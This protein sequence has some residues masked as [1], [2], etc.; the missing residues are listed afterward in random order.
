ME[1]EK[2]TKTDVLIAVGSG[3]LT[4]TMDA[5]FIKDIDLREAHK[6]GSE[7]VQSFVT[8]FAR[9]RG[10]KDHDFANIVRKLE[11]EYPMAGDK[12]TNDFGSGNNHHLRDFSHHPTP[13][14]LF[15]SLLMQFT[16][17]GYG[18]DVHGNLIS[19][20]IPN[21]EPQSVFE[22][23][24]NGTIK[25]AFHL[26][27]DMAGSSSSLD[28]GKE[29]TGIP[30]PMLS[31]LKM[32]S[33]CPGIKRLFG[34]AANENAPNMNR[35]NF[36]EAC[37]D[38]FLGKTF[39]LRDENGRIIKESQIPF[40]LRTELGIVNE[41]LKNKQYI[42]VVLNEVIISA[43]YFISRLYD[44][45][46]HK[47]TF[48]LSDVAQINFKRCLPWGNKSL[49]H[50]RMI[51]TATFS[52]IDLS[53]AGIKA[54]IKNKDNKAGFALDFIQATNFWGLGDFALAS[55]SE[56]A[57][58]LRKSFEQFHSIAQKKKDDIIKSI[59]NGD[60]WLETAEM[61]AST[62]GMIAKMGSPIGF[63]F[64]AISVYEELS[65]SIK[66]YN[67]AKEERIKI[68]KACSERIALIQEN[69][70]LIDRT[71]S[72]Y[73]VSNY[74]VFEVAFN[75]MDHAVAT[76]NSDEFIEGN[77]M[78]QEKLDYDT[79]FKNQSEFDSLMGENSAF[80]L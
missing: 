33:S 39:L 21:W 80:K 8:A 11:K 72:D 35:Y 55:G 53:T 14:G 13:L 36:S 16:G 30:G 71:V 23:I 18:T 6:W 45:I 64:A 70:E 68:E 24:S 40:D 47:D 63:V 73:F 58:L 69:Q 67:I 75:K 57:M 38:L 7:K 59:P 34:E 48:D 46:S 60:E 25:W 41:S 61:G 56:V 54:Y 19:V 22:S 17:K 52:T 10:I 15:F 29:G 28:V 9:S 44:E 12:L 50:M 31:T 74:E 26:I 3:A 1:Q 76:N 79:Q 62:A 51:A 49:K 43:F 65:E 77:V 78:I 2:L 37:T 4:G 27:S 5:V 42:P 66:E 32:I 20:E